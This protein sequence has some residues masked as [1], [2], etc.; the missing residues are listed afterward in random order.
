MP[1]DLTVS[2]SVPPAIFPFRVM[3]P[4]LADRF[5]SRVPVCLPP[6]TTHH[7]FP[8]PLSNPG[9]PANMPRHVA[10]LFLGC[11]LRLPAGGDGPGGSHFGLPWRT[12][13]V[14]HSPSWVAFHALDVPEPLLT[15]SWVR[16]K[17][18]G[19]LNKTSA[20]LFPLCCVHNATLF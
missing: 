13:T 2:V 14:R 19:V 12:N 16:Q 18:G 15:L 1:Q 10:V 7:F 4:I 6:L 17:D 5:A 9:T 20:T 11:L 8:F 3:P